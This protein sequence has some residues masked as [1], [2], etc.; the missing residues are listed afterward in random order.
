LEIQ[1]ASHPVADGLEVIEVAEASGAAAGG[2]ND[3]VDRLN[4]RRGDAAGV[5]GDANGF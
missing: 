4:G 1:A 3:A 2:L 5:A